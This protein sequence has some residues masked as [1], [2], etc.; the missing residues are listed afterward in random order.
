MF[1]SDLSGTRGA[2]EVPRPESR[3]EAEKVLT[4]APLT[5]GYR[6]SIPAVFYAA[7]RGG[8]MYPTMLGDVEQMLLHPVVQTPYNYFKSAISTVTFHVKSKK[9][10]VAKFVLGQLQ[11]FWQ[12][13][14]DRMQD[15]Y[16]YGWLGG[17]CTYERDRQTGLLGLRGIETFHPLDTWAL[18]HRGEYRGVSLVSGA[19]E[20]ATAQGK[21][22][23]PQRQ[24]GKQ[25]LWGATHGWPAKGFWLSHNRRW[26]RFYG[27][28]QL[29][30]AWRPWRR[31]ATRDAA[32]EVVDGAI[33]RFAYKGP[34]M[35]YPEKSFQKA[36]GEVDFDAAQ[37]QARVFCENAKA[38]VSVALPNTRD[39]HGNY[40]WE[41]DWPDHTIA[42]DG[43][44]AYCDKLEAQISLGIGVPPELIQAS[45]T[46]SGWSG[47]KIPLLG[48]FHSQQKN[49]RLQVWA[50]KQQ[51]GDSLAVWNFGKD[52]TFEVAVEIKLPAAV[53]G[54]Q[55]QQPGGM[56]GGGVQS[57]PGQ[58][59]EG[60]GDSDESNPL[61]GLMGG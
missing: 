5:R 27:R 34:I 20:M 24:H 22:Q 55:P 48:F 3:A 42:V 17:E 50:W 21:N 25:S 45:D 26:D 29:Y 38:G 12:R 6:P 57:A 51:I 41:I 43:L 19:S 7:T 13:C 18:T 33:Y 36:N 10:H 54:E 59:E 46:G 39:E 61:A 40:L 31:L 14:L 28:S 4:G 23:P 35:R 2:V 15:V 11:R 52:A 53:S 16:D 44:L 56:A 49:A 1:Q 8:Q 9:K 30:G 47:R 32:E 37:N 60:A 58:A